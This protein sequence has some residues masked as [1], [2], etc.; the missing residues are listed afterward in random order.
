MVKPRVKLIGLS[1]ILQPAPVLPASAWAFF[2]PR[3]R[4]IVV[5]RLKLVAQ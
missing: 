3:Q 1:V 4:Y 5:P 2:I